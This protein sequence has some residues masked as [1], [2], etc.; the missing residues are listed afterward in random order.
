[1]NQ[2]TQKWTRK[3]WI[4]QFYLF[5]C[6]YYFLRKLHAFSRPLKVND[7][8]S[9]FQGFPGRWEPWICNPRSIILFRM[10]HLTKCPSGMPLDPLKIT[11]LLFIRYALLARTGFFVTSLHNIYIIQS[12][13][14]SN[15]WSWISSQMPSILIGCQWG[16][17]VSIW[18]YIWM[19][20]GT[21]I[22]LQ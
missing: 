9:G 5:P 1:M 14:T 21:Y 13:D 20:S 22:P 17:L 16:F 11:P 7:K 19:V 4:D 18:C 3:H 15:H 8:I 2:K 10:H 6:F 12:T